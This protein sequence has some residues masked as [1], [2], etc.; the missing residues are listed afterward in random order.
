MSNEKKVRILFTIRACLWLIAAGATAYWIRY[1]FKLY[2]YG[3]IDEHEYAVKLRPVMAKGL[4]IAVV[5]IAVCL[6]L[7]S[8]SDKIK[9]KIKYTVD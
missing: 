8:I 5:C 1:S 7:R 2:E 4:L 6:V 9:Q 3:V